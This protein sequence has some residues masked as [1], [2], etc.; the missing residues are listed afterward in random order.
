MELSP[1]L[2]AASRAVT[3][4]ILSILVNSKVQYHIQN[5]PP[6]VPTQIQ[7]SPVHTT[8]FYKSKIHFNVIHL[9]S[10]VDQTMDILPFLVTP[11][12]SLC[13]DKR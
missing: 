5:S 8:P 4:E 12:I 6:L 3:E 10:D 7:I 1:S 13:R 2:E 9:G 11:T